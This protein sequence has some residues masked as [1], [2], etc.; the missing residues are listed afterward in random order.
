MS[1][2]PVRV[3]QRMHPTHLCN[4]EPSWGVPYSGASLKKKCE[5][6]L[7]GHREWTCRLVGEGDGEMNWDS[8]IDIYVLYHV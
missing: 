6:K 4:S 1:D 3:M 7:Y 8:G 2:A 5:N